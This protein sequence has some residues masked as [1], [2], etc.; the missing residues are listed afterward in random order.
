MNI[1]VCI[2]QTFDSE[3][4][5]QLT[6][7]GMI[8]DSLAKLIINP[9]DEYAVEEALLVK[10]AHGGEVSLVS[11]DRREPFIALRQGLAMGAD[12]AV[13]LDCSELPLVDNYLYAEILG[14]W[15]E[16]QEFDLILCGKMAID[17]GASEIPSRLAEVLDVPQ[18]NIV[19]SLKIEGQRVHATRDIDGGQARVEVDLPC[20]L[21]AQ[22]GL[23]TP[24]YPSMRRIME[25]KR[26]T[27]E[28]VQLDALGFSAPELSPLVKVEEY[29][30]PPPREPGRILEEPH[31]RAVAELF[32]ALSEEEKVV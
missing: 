8:D 17:D 14:R 32:R 18:V 20:V 22:K 15:L 25:A 26:K 1:V 19:S 4:K 24:R 23:N 10:E 30:I 16:T 28:N 21:S 12:R 7:E 3:A 2:K 6:E 13:W 27:I 9:F 5:I 11:V 31:E 29:V